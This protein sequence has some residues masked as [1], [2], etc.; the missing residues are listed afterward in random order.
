MKEN[1]LWNYGY[2]L[3][4][5]LGIFWTFIVYDTNLKLIMMFFCL[6]G[7]LFQI[8]SDS[9]NLNNTQEGKDGK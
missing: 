9:Q 5:F 7:I 8:W 4:I 2:Y 3:G 6:L 1:S